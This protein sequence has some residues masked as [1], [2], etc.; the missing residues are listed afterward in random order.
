[1]PS[2]LP[3]SDFSSIYLLLKLFGVLGLGIFALL[4]RKKIFELLA[5]EQEV[6]VQTTLATNEAKET[7]ASDNVIALT[8]KK[9]DLKQQLDQLT[10]SQNLNPSDAQVLDFFAAEQNQLNQNK[11]K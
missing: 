10:S 1:M 11:T 6:N 5:K 4:S 3:A 7:K 2:S 9:Q 8:Q